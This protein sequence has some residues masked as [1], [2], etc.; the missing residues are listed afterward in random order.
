L[1]M[2]NKL[3]DLVT[4]YKA[5]AVAGGLGL[6][7]EVT[8]ALY[9][10]GIEVGCTLNP[11][12]GVALSGD[13][14]LPGKFK[15]TIEGASGAVTQQ[16]V[17]QLVIPVGFD[18]YAFFPKNKTR[19]YFSA[20]GGALISMMSYQLD[21]NS[22]I[23]QKNDLLGIGPCVKMRLGHQWLLGKNKTLDAGLSGLWG[24]ISS[25]KGTVSTDAG[26][27]DITAAKTADGFLW[28][29]PENQVGTNGMKYLRLDYMSL[30]ARL[31]VAFQF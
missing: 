31:S 22:G 29:I 6:E 1:I 7:A 27:Y 24:S 3:E 13:L 20:G 8:R 16:Q 21:I 26:D 23:S 11:K 10:G 28:V 30:A 18:V 19:F 14:Y 4:S 25:F 2:Q 12:M 17:S 9:V 5:I 15:S